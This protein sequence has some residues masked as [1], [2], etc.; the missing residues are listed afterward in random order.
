MKTIMGR[1]LGLEGG[2]EGAMMGRGVGS[3]VRQK[4]RRCRPLG[5]VWSRGTE[6]KSS[7][8]KSLSGRRWVA[9]ERSL[10][11]R[12]EGFGSGGM[13]AVDLKF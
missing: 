3:A 5:F 2:E 8:T 11:G 7:R 4:R 6:K 9:E 1:G 10:A 12:I 13:L